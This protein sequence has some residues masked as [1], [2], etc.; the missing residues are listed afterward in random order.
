MIITIPLCLLF[1]CIVIRKQTFFQ[2]LPAIDLFF[3]NHG[4]VLSDTYDTFHLSLKP[5]CNMST[6]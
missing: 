6:F 5:S 4:E 1:V 2:K 3:Y